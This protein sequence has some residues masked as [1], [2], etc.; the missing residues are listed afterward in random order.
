M[1]D[2]KQKRRKDERTARRQDRKARAEAMREAV[3]KTWGLREDEFNGWTQV[4]VSQEDVDGASRR[5][6]LWCPF[7]EAIRRAGFEMEVIAVTPAT[8][9]INDL[10]MFWPDY[11]AAAVATWDDAGTVPVPFVFRI[12]VRP[13]P[14]GKY[15]SPTRN[16]AGWNKIPF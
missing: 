7:G 15:D 9:S 11:L 12:P 5:S 8:L 3:Q 14:D 13:K 6:R 10:T 2:A 1:G 4:T 16:L